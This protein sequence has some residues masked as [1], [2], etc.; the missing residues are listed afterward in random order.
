MAEV[1]VWRMSSS[2]NAISLDLPLQVQGWVLGVDANYHM[3]VLS[4]DQ[5][6][7]SEQ[8]CRCKY[9][10]KFI[11]VLLATVSMATLSYFTAAGA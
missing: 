2:G 9:G 6:E 4:S 7:P 5:G 11:V 3:A 8:K 10:R 1:D